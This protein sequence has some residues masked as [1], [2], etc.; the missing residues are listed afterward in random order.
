MDGCDHVGGGSG[1][2]EAPDF[3]VIHDEE[4]IIGLFLLALWT[5]YRL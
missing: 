2:L 5:A 3:F 4:A 1:A